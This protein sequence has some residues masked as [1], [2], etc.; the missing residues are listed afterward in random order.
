[1]TAS[2]TATATAVQEEPEPDENQQE[3]AVRE[4]GDRVLMAAV[5][6]TVFLLH[7]PRHFTGAST[8]DGEGVSAKWRSRRRLYLMGCA[9][10]KGLP[11][12]DRELAALCP[13]RQRDQPL[14]RFVADQVD[15][16]PPRAAVQRPDRNPVRKPHHSLLAACA[17]PV[18][19]TERDGA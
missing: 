18:S 11:G 8:R 9:G 5:G 10:V 3:R 15:R 19:V 1:M 14:V 2:P 16:E 17:S 6:E 12:R 13:L 4:P 7:P